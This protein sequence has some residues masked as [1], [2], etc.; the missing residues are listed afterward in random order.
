MFLLCT[1]DFLS[2]IV[3]FACP[4]VHCV[5]GQID[6]ATENGGRLKIISLERENVKNEGR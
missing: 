2:Q 5:A 1:S 3:G 4:P 6:C